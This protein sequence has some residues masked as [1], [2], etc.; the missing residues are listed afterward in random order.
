MNDSLNRRMHNFLGRM[1][2]YFE[3][4]QIFDSGAMVT[5]ARDFMQAL[6]DDRANEVKP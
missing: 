2:V 4:P 1:V 6:D 5:E 3:R